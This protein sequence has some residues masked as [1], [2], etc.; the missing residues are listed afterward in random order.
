M[1]KSELN[2]VFLP[3][4]RCWVLSCE[5]GHDV[6]PAAERHELPAGLQGG[7]EEQDHSRSFITRA[8]S[9]HL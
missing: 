7:Q 6:Q 4:S 9:A 3:V 2:I 5:A 1:N 8:V